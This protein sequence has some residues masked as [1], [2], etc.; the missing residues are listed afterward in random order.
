MS[1]LI[2]YSGEEIKCLG[3]ISIPCCYNEP[4]WEDTKFYVV[5]VPGSAIVGLQTSERLK[6]VVIN[7]I[8]N[9]CSNIKRS[10]KVR[11][12]EHMMQRYPRN[13]DTVGDF[14]GGED[15]IIDDEA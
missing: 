5:V 14:K 10:T 1:K 3:S 9:E 8:Q 4:R 12:L 15:L 6:I 11:Y 2:S 7:N 13:F